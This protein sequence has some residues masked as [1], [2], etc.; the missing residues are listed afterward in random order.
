MPPRKDRAS[1]NRTRSRA[2]SP[3]TIEGRSSL[4][5]AFAACAEG[6]AK[7]ANVD[8]PEPNADVLARIFASIHFDERLS[9][10]DQLGDAGAGIAEAREI[11]DSRQMRMRE[12][13]QVI[14][15][16]QHIHPIAAHG[17]LPVDLHLAQGTYLVPVS[18]S[19]PEKFF[20]EPLQFQ[21]KPAFDS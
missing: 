12:L 11:F 20:P 4:L 15:R 7:P 9:R 5:T 18:L 17:A 6:C 19:H 1:K 16:F 10:L 21:Q 3:T 14:E 8:H 13:S 2:A